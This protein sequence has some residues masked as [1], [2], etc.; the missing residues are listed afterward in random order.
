MEFEMVD[1]LIK[2]ART[3]F[4]TFMVST[5]F[6]G[7]GGNETA[8]EPPTIP[9]PPSPSAPTF[10]VAGLENRIIYDL[11]IV[12]GLL[13]ASTDQGLYKEAT[14]NNWQLMGSDTWNI[15]DL[16]IMADGRWIVSISD[17][18]GLYELF[19]S[20]D[21][22]QNW[23]K[24]DHDFGGTNRPVSEPSPVFR[25][26]EDSA[27]LYAVGT[28][29]LGQSYN[30]GHSWELMDGDWD[31][32]A[33]GL[34]ALTLNPNHTDIWYGGQG[35]IEN[36][37]LVRYPMSSGI[38]TDLSANTTDLLPSPSTV[39]NIVFDPVDPQRIFI[40]AEGGIIQTRDEGETFQAFLL[41]N[42]HR[43]Y[44]DMISTP[45][46]Q[47]RFFT[48]GWTKTPNTQPLIL[49]VS[50][51]DGENWTSYTHPDENING[52]VYSMA[53]RIENE[54]LVIYLGTYKGGVVRVTDLP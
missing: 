2:K 42:E 38:S 30:S 47:G 46:Q 1:L 36:L 54:E 27:V 50:V 3:L 7:C 26:T 49:E 34:H 23:Q 15:Q 32:F 22:G 35:A 51:D 29:S 37:V 12:D 4:I 43:F 13:F 44:F 5:A 11:D 24:I 25:F 10:S 14:Q 48:A 53:S 39:N 45:S 31:G 33:R 19:E 6:F 8:S 40:L 18:D 9:T 16:E 52:G 28:A 41:N 20:L 17:A 21:E